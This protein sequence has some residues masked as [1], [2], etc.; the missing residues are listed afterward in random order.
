MIVNLLIAAVRSLFPAARPTGGSIRGAFSLLPQHFA[1]LA[2]IFAAAC[3][4]TTVARMLAAV[5]SF[6]E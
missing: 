1:P 4:I 6:R 5:K 3:W 2:L